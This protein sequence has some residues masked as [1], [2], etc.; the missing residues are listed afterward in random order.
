MTLDITTLHKNEHQVK[1]R[2]NT[3]SSI[4]S[5]RWEGNQPC[6][7]M[8][9]RSLKSQASIRTRHITS[10]FDMPCTSVIWPV[11]FSLTL[12]LVKHCGTQAE[13]THEMTWLRE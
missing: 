5:T 11:P 1:I 3:K 9:I 2:F 13:I 12:S 7:E 4:L 10:A 8:F 6:N